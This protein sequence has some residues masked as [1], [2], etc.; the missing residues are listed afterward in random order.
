MCNEIDRGEKIQKRHWGVS[1][2]N[3]EVVK[4]QHDQSEKGNK[5]LILGDI[6]K[7]TV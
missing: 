4:G 1:G 7:E 2:S 5:V 3:H 6:V